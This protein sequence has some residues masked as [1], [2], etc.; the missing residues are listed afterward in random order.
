M[1]KYEKPSVKMVKLQVQNKLLTGS[2]KNIT[3]VQDYTYHEYVE[4]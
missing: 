1:K 3:T 2:S 4:E